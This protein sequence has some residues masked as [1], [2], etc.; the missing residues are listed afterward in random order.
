MRCEGKETRVYL[1]YGEFLLIHLLNS[2]GY[3]LRMEMFVS[4][5]SSNFPAS[6][7]QKCVAAKQLVNTRLYAVYE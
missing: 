1:S 5:F 6:S 3:H 4:N 2:G 7:V